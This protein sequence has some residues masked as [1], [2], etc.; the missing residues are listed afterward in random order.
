[1]RLLYDELH[2]LVIC[3]RVTFN[4]LVIVHR[5]LNRHAPQYR[6]NHSAAQ[7]VSIPLTY[8]YC[9]YHGTN[10]AHT[11]SGLSPLLVHPPETGSKALSATQI[12]PKPLSDNC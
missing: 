9:T 5:Y 10:S 7:N 12:P 6:A 2:W 4:L 11:V 8:I 3:D 1:M